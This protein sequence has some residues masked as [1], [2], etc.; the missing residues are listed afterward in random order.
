MKEGME[1]CMEWDVEIYGKAMKER[2]E[3]WMEWDVEI[4]CGENR[5]MKKGFI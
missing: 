4:R 1:F 5:R 3:F 2:I